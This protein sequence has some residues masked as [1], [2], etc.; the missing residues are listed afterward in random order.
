ML[1]SPAA[2]NLSVNAVIPTRLTIPAADHWQGGAGKPGNVGAS[3]Q[4]STEKDIHR[5]DHRG[6]HSVRCWPSRGSWQQT[7]AS[8]SMSDPEGRCR[9]NRRRTR[10]NGAS[11]RCKGRGRGERR[12]REEG[13][14]MKRAAWPVLEPSSAKRKKIEVNRFMEYIYAALPCTTQ[15]GL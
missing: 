4:A 5:P 3:R 13:K 14:R 12:G 11:R 2:F 10:Y 7:M 1:A 8:N 9:W 6:G 15:Q